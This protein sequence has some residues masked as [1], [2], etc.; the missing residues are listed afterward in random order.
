[1][2][3]S[4]ALLASLLVSA[5]QAPNRLGPGGL[6]YQLDLAPGEVL[7]EYVW[8]GGAP[9][10]FQRPDPVVTIPFGE[11]GRREGALL[12]LPGNRVDESANTA[13]AL[14]VGQN[15]GLGEG[16]LGTGLALTP[17]TYLHYRLPQ[18]D[19]E[20][21][22]WTVS[23]WMRPE[24]VAFG[25][26]FLVMDGVLD[27]SLQSD[28]RIR[29]SVAGGPV[30]RSAQ[31]L[32]A[33][34]WS[35]VHVSADPLQIGH[36]RLAVDGRASSIALPSG[37]LPMPLE[38]KLGDLGRGNLGP[39]A[40]LDEFVLEARPNSTAQAE[41]QRL[42]PVASGP[43]QLEIRTSFGLRTV[44]PIAGVIGSSSVDTA[45]N[46]GLGK[47]DGAAVKNA[48]L[49][50][51]PARWQRIVT[52]DA[53]AP[54][55]THPIVSVGGGRTFVF[56]GE[57]RD[58]IVWPMVNTSDTWLF[59]SA[60]QRWSFVNT[61]SAPQPRC[62]MPAAY[63]PDHDLVFVYG[64]WRNDYTPGNLFNDAWAFHVGQRR[65]E[66]LFPT[67]PGPGNSSDHGLLYL[68]ALRKFLLLRD[69]AAWT[70]DP[71]SRSWS[72]LG[73]ANVVDEFGQPA[74][75]A[76]GASTALTL[77]ASTG[78]VVVYGGS[79]GN[80]PTTF[81]DTTA[82]YDV[83]THTYTVLA[84]PVR[85]SPR[86]R[87]G[88]GF[89][90]RLGRVV[91]FGGVQ[92]QF[93]TRLDDLWVFDP[94]SRLWTELLA[95]NAPGRRGGYYGMAYDKTRGSFVLSCGRQAY[96]VWLDETWELSLAPT[97]TGTALYTLDLQSSGSLGR[98]F[99]DVSEPA[100]ARV[101]FFV[102]RSDNLRNWD[103]WRPAGGVAG[104]RRYVQVA[105][106][107]KPS[108]AG[109]SPVVRSFGFR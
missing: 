8:D 76:F 92:D 28:G 10:P 27:L 16:Y 61:S 38:L 68:P 94:A 39:G 52:D 43:H 108:S 72:A 82:L 41:E 24:A 5:Q 25:R 2:S 87:G 4:L 33:G 89:D 54:R 62:H 6:E 37:P 104:P 32:T 18:L 75:Y 30:L 101:S 29:A 1:M 77:D 70:F 35:F 53:P 88:F 11:R 21:P 55:T 44:E 42:P 50:W 96:D 71:T 63:S 105:V 23:F 106:G 103:G 74:S 15:L 67:G 57:T 81:G 69:R 34:R 80:P 9:V 78:L 36:M 7:L 49:R 95:S 91:L 20:L 102:R 83:G 3:S 64:G 65:W 40:A 17:S 31:G 98:W 79:Y 93:S 60:T 46:L 51:A 13:A 22:G 66:Q 73:P 109:E 99:A 100:D 90:E 48:E 85:P 26:A 45:A 47:L 84:P 58:A 107:L 14:V 97:R 12:Y 19:R 86:V 59:D 56:G